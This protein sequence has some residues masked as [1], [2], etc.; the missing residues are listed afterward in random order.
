LGGFVN[1]VVYN[2]GEI[3]DCETQVIQGCIGRN[4]LRGLEKLLAR[5]RSPKRHDDAVPF[6]NIRMWHFLPLVVRQITTELVVIC[7]S[8]YA[9][10]TPA[11]TLWICNKYLPCNNEHDNTSKAQSSPE[12]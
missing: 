10:N 3:N 6:P 8:H 4:A 11:T 5:D 9:P 12:R 1:R 2:V 7:A